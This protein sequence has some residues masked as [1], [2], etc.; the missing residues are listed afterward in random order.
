[1]D[2]TSKNHSKFLIMAHLI[3]ACKYRKKLLVKLGEQVKQLMF[4]IAKEKNFEI[5]ERK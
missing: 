5:K 1:M 2:Y 4:D 3:F